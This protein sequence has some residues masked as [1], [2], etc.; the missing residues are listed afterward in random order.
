MNWKK[1]CST[2]D[3]QVASG[4]LGRNSECSN[5]HEVQCGYHYNGSGGKSFGG[6]DKWPHLSVKVSFQ[7]GEEAKRDE[8]AKQMM[9]LIAEFFEPTKPG[10]IL[11]PIPTQDELDERIEEAKR[12]EEADDHLSDEERKSLVE[13]FK[14]VRGEGEVAAGWNEAYINIIYG[15]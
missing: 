2:R 9:N 12:R 13:A 15:I 14:R 3:E 7:E 4:K 11:Q 10:L 8:L 5:A 6:A 1:S